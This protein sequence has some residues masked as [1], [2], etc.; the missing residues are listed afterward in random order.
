MPTYNFHSDC[1]NEDFEIFMTI[2]EYTPTQKCPTCGKSN[3]VFRNYVEDNVSGN[4][5]KRTLGALAEHSA[6]KMSSDEKE[7]LWRKH[8]AYRLGPKPELPAGME[9][10]NKDNPF[11]DQNRNKKPKRQIK[12]RTNVH[13]SG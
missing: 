5:A 10:I 2:S 12:N 1:C 8:N 11:H 3:K 7:H 6:S 4:I 13:I 9:R